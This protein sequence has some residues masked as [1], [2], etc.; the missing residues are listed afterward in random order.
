ML[1]FIRRPFPAYQASQRGAGSRSDQSR[2]KSRFLLTAGS[3]SSGRRTFPSSITY[4]QKDQK[5]GEQDASLATCPGTT[6]HVGSFTSGDQSWDLERRLASEPLLSFRASLSPCTASVSPPGTKPVCP[7]KVGS[8]HTP[9]RRL[10]APCGEHA[11]APARYP[12]SQPHSPCIRARVDGTA[13]GP[14]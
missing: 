4:S 11:C 7:G 10:V 1:V 14:P 12:L 2:R 3:H 9:Q 8:S 6:F 5:V 13:S